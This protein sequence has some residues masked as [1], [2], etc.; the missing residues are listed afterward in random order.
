MANFR[1]LTLNTELKAKMQKKTSI[2]K[3]W[4]LRTISHLLLIKREQGFRSEPYRERVSKTKTKKKMVHKMQILK[5][6]R[7]NFF[8]IIISGSF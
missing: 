7:L 6:L 4:L 1:F 2:E 5:S 3:K 8:G